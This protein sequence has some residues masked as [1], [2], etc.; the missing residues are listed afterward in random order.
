MLPDG[1]KVWLNAAS[2]LTYPVSFTGT[3]RRVSVKGEAYFEV[4]ENKAR[5]FIVDIGSGSSIEVLGTHFNVNSYADEGVVQT[6][7]LEGSIKVSRRIT[8]RQADAV[9]IKPGQQARQTVTADIPDGE[10]LQVVEKVNLEKVMAWKNG[11]FYFQ[12]AGLLQVMRQL[13]RWY[14]IDV[15]FTGKVPVLRINGK[16]DRG[17]TLQEVLEF[18]TKLEVHSTLEGRTLIVE[19]N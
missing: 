9:V 3:E 12:D 5:P 16:M 2:S 4:T 10:R 19:E 7:L 1:T 15:Q 11:I 6:T 18:L 13:E 17:L 14:D 8:G